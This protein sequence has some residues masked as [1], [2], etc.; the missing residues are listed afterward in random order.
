M[1][2]CGITIYFIYSNYANNNQDSE[3]Y[4]FSRMSANIDNYVQNT[5]S[6]DTT[7]EEKQIA[8]KSKISSF[9]TPIVDDDDN[10]INN[11]EITCKRISGT[12][13]EANSEFSFCD[14]VGEPTS[15]DGYKEAHAILDG[16]VV[17]S[18]GG[19]NCQV[20]TTIYN[21]AK[22]ID[23]VEITE[24]HEHGKDVGYIEEGEDATVAYDYF[25]L[26]FE[27]NNDFDLELEAYIKD[28]KV[29]VDIY[30]VIY[31]G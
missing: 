13:V 22:K 6:V 2:F 14:T 5:Q 11:I 27:N 9:S 17:D 15:E 25:D 21:A 18:I 23:N 7:D 20:S 1:S 3:D 8:S 16:E 28:E 26:K 31:E 24:R 19:G 30:K 29:C 12:I 10:R 4:S